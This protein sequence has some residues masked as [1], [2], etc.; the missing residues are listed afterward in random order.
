MCRSTHSQADELYTSRLEGSI[1][2]KETLFTV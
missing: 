1:A 2:G